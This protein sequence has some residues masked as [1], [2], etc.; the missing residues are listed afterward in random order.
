MSTPTEVR[1]NNVK[2]QGNMNCIS[3]FSPQGELIRCF[4]KTGSEPG[5]FNSPC[6][7]T[8]NTRGQIVIADTHNQRLQTFDL[9]KE[10][11]RSKYSGKDVKGIAENVSK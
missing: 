1:N 9:N 3:I 7:I 6:G 2:E 8:M 11:D 10:L 5:M 4:G